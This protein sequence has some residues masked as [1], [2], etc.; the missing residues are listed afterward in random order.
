MHAAPLSLWIDVTDFARN[1]T[2]N[3]C[4]LDQV[5]RTVVLDEF[6]SFRPWR[7]FS[8][9]CRGVSDRESCGAVHTAQQQ[10]AFRV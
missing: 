1:R 6:L 5:Q 10:L 9:G 7:A 8:L 2:G 4:N 3:T